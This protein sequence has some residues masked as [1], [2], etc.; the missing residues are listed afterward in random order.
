MIRTFILVCAL[1][2]GTGAQA[3]IIRTQCQTEESR[4]LRYAS[5]A[6]Y[7]A[8]EE[9]DPWRG[10]LSGCQMQSSV[11]DS[12]TITQRRFE[13]EARADLLKARAAEAAKCPEI[14]DAIMSLGPITDA[15]RSTV[16][17]EFDR[18]MKNNNAELADLKKWQASHPQCKH[19]EWQK[20]AS[21][22][23]EGVRQDP[24]KDCSSKEDLSGK[25]GKCSVDG[26]DR[27]WRGSEDNMEM[28]DPATNP[29]IAKV[30]C[31]DALRSSGLGDG[32]YADPKICAQ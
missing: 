31:A 19:V 28:V 23:V 21:L 27:D 18:L 16:K 22:I 24:S 13:A 14:A 17:T 1:L 25:G 6:M 20:C 29:L 26:N 9:S 4:G 5:K 8:A 10:C 15:E 30:A 11:A 3:E 32:S 7:Q 12:M 2:A